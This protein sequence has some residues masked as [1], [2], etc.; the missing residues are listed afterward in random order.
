MHETT[1][2]RVCRTAFVVGCVLPTLCAVAWIA[3]LHRPWRGNDWQRML[4]QRL[5]VRATVGE[6]RSPRPGVTQLLD[7]QFADLRSER[8]LGSI[9]ELRIESWKS[10]LVADRL[11]ISAA[12]LPAFA[13]AIATWIS[14]EAMPA[15]QLQAESLHVVGP[16]GKSFEL[17]NVRLRSFTS[18]HTHKQ[19]ELQAEGQGGSIQLVVEHHA[20]QAEPM[21]LASLDTGEERLPAWLFADL[22]P[23]FQRCSDAQFTGVL[24]V[25]S[26]SQQLVGNMHGRLEE[27]ALEPWFD[28][29]GFDRL[30]GTAN[31]ELETLQWQNRRMSVL[32]GRL[33]AGAGKINRSLL[34][35]LTKLLV[36]GPGNMLARAENGTVDPWLDFDELACN[37]QI[38]SAGITLFGACDLDESRASGCLLA[39]GGQPLLLQPACRDVPLGR[40]VQVLM[41]PGTS[42]VPATV[43]ASRMA[44][45]LPLPRASAEE[46]TSRKNRVV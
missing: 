28:S 19:M 40:L 16:D 12:Q 26:L 3:F 1:Q 14:A 32:Q 37:F 15:M 33:R 5:H 46:A 8:S 39:A 30:E 25:E 22:V 20:G 4:Q 38:S 34:A 45:G 43:E 23:G 31:L 2:R 9:G 29:A 17:K 7:V 41:L 13:T 10:L 18:N 42:W 24:R 44:D 35:K 6:I 36:C 27:I 11:E 21:V